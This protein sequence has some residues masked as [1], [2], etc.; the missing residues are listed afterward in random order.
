MPHPRDRLRPVAHGRKLRSQQGIGRLVSCGNYPA[1][2]NEQSSA[3]H[4]ESALLVAGGLIVAVLPALAEPNVVRH[5]EDCG[6]NV[7]DLRVIAPMGEREHE[8]ALRQ[9]VRNQQVARL[10]KDLGRYSRELFNMLV[11]AVRC[12]SIDECSNSPPRRVTWL[13][14]P[15]R[16]NVFGAGIGRRYSFRSFARALT[17]P[18]GDRGDVSAGTSH[19]R[20]CVRT[21]TAIQPDAPLFTVS[22]ELVF[23][24]RC[25]CLITEGRQAP[26]RSR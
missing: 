5:V 7:V 10:F 4:S 17:S 25:S 21:L 24:R 16:P 6:A 14:E 2:G 3:Q 15:L 22:V 12:D 23:E 13:E 19:I 26:S 8:L 11:T 1:G 18:A 20:E 9:D